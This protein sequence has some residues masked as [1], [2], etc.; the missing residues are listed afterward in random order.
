MFCKAF[1]RK[2][3]DCYKVSGKPPSWFLKPLCRRITRPTISRALPLTCGR[4]SWGRFEVHFRRKQ[5]S[6]GGSPWCAF[7]TWNQRSLYFVCAWAGYRPLGTAYS[8]TV[9]FRPHLFGQITF[10][11]MLF[12]RSQLSQFLWPRGSV[13]LCKWLMFQLWFQERNSMRADC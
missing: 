8:I 11:Q 10:G 1:Y 12:S 3:L 7:R 9:Y 6:T 4:G 13:L 2:S 5:S